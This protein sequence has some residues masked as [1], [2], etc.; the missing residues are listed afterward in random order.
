VIVQTPDRFLR[1]R[2]A[3]TPDLVVDAIAALS[4]RLK[5]PTQTTTEIAKLLAKGQFIPNFGAD[6]LDAL[7]GRPGAC[8]ASRMDALH[9]TSST[10]SDQTHSLLPHTVRSLC[11]LTP[12]SRARALGECMTLC[13][14]RSSPAS[15]LACPCLSR[16][17]PS[18]HDVLIGAWPLGVPATLSSLVT[19]SS[20]WLCGAPTRH[21]NT[22]SRSVAVRPPLSAA[23]GR[24]AQDL[25]DQNA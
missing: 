23:N 4:Q 2:L 16:R 8:G 21:N 19:H 6:L 25:R 10:Y 11:Y 12:C 18:R 13:G 20:A 5:N 1:D 3:E 22:S 17:A 9:D 24:W 14:A 7:G 15:P